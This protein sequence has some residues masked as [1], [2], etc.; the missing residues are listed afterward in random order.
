MTF[1]QPRDGSHKFSQTLL[2]YLWWYV[3]WSLSPHPFMPQD[4][5]GDG[6]FNI[7][8]NLPTFTH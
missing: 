4:D 3:M 2:A 6:G 5:H 8:S 1:H 7:G